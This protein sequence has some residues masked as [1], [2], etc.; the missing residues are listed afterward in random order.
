MAKFIL[1]P[2]NFD[3][4]NNFA[5]SDNIDNSQKDIIKN[6]MLEHVEVDTKSES[7]LF[8]LRS[9]EMFT[10]KTEQDLI[11]KIMEVLPGYSKIKF[12]CNI[13][14]SLAV[15]KPIRRISSEK[16]KKQQI[17]KGKY[18][19]IKDIDKF[20]DKNIVIQGKVFGLESKDIKGGKKLHKFCLYDGTD[21]ISAKL[22]S[23][24]DLNF[25]NNDW[26]SC[27]GKVEYNNYEKD[28][29]VFITGIKKSSPPKRTDN[30]IEKRIELHAHSKM[31]AMDGLS[32][33]SKLVETA[34]NFGHTALALTDHGVVQGFPEF[35]KHCKKNGIKP[36]FGMEGYLVD[37]TS[38]DFENIKK[39]K[40]YHINIL[41]K[42]RKGLRNLYYLVSMAHLNDFYRRPRI[43]K[44]L[45]IENR[46][47]LLL[48]TA[49]EAGELFQA[50]LK[51]PSNNEK[52]KKIAEFYDFIEIMPK[53]N[54]AFLIR[55]KVFE[56][57]KD[58][59]EVSKRF[60]N[61]AK[62]LGKFCVATGDLH[63]VN[64]EDSF[65]R[66]I[67][68]YTQGYEES[69]SQAELYYK[70]TEEML[71]EFSY[72]GDDISREV[73][74]EAPK[75]I[76]DMIE[77]LQPVP[78]GFYPPRIEG[79]E[80]KLKKMVYDNAFKKYGNPLPKI[81]Q[82][83]IEKELRPIC[84]NRY[85]DLYYIAYKIVNYSIQ[86][87]YQVGSRG[88]VGSSL[89]ANLAEITE[90]NALPPHYVCPKCK[91][92][93]LQDYPEI[94]CGAD[95][96]DKDCPKCSSKMKKDGYR[97]PFEVFMG[98]KGEKVPDIDLNFSGE[99][100]TEAH[101]FAESIFGADHSFKAGTISTFQE[102]AVKACLDKYLQEKNVMKRKAEVKRI[103]GECVGVKR[104]TGQHPG[105][106]I[107]LPEGNEIYEFCPVQHPA[108]DKSKKVITTHFDYHVME[109]QLV[110]LDML[111][112]DNP[113]IIKM[114]EDLTGLDASKIPLDD[115][116]TLLLF[117]KV[118]T[119]GIP[120]FG[121]SFVRQVL[122]DVIPKTFGDIVRICGLT[123]GTD[124]WLN[125]AKELVASGVK[126][127]QIITM[128]DDILNFLQQKGID[129]SIAFKIMETV[130]K[131]RKLSDEQL[132]VM[133]D[134]NVPEW[135]IESCEKIKYLFPKAHAVA[136]STMA[137]RI[138]YFKVHYP[139]A[140]YAAYF[141][142]RPDVF[143][144]KSMTSG[145][146]S[147]KSKMNY[148]KNLPMGE[149]SAR[150]KELRTTLE[151]AL[152]FCEHGFEFFP[153][154]LYRSDS[155]AFIMIKD[156]GL[157]CPFSAMEGIGTQAAIN[158]IKAR[159]K[160]KF[161]SIEDLGIRAKLNK[162]VIES[163]RESGALK[164]LPE[165]EQMNLF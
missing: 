109:S 117:E 104:T 72:L 88:S 143:D 25:D 165:T 56:S 86:K 90:V 124:V 155:N 95:L 82:N 139:L 153:L 62:E 14:N 132:K 102:K 18:I 68:Q 55:N 19:F 130:R 70:T 41:A 16:T 152:E 15:E 57:D 149:L 92:F 151:I 128:R 60:Y 67:I 30:S 1:R 125:N 29:E 63:F 126:F 116:D 32:D 21:S 4:I 84:S 46:E 161:S 101:K 115:K 120:E 91:Y 10:K 83:R 78:D 6:S 106:I 144:Y 131:G 113:T 44:S 77:E 146:D 136:Y 11:D 111:G 108:D 8:V 74:I 159:D 123:H 35:Y 61:I 133:K 36:I 76:S 52:L 13:N 50:Y 94:E 59:E 98:F 51:D 164:G 127:S 47:G 45:I 37:D 158:V 118:K 39:S 64:P 23:K 87:G 81:V 135:Y 54:N 20:I 69:G 89:V 154:D 122:S 3:I 22:F 129:D 148:L 33:I 48:G 147:I 40:S 71:E 114:L 112:H 142:I 75:K 43:R 31:S 38:S 160:K 73:V 49:C 163:L 26:I 134:N 156:K 42:N 27:S 138:A 17:R 119:L 162:S 99:I 157:L 145:V 93:E 9:K 2:S 97:I 121:T 24:K 150:D 12:K 140:F 58:L 105:G 103:I 79:A 85:S 96:P 110:K 28:L 107:V 53:S 7:I 34:K 141:S 100:Q 65:N 80:E 66:E 5:D 137:F